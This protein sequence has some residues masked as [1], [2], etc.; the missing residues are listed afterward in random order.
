MANGETDLNTFL[1]RF[2]TCAEALEVEGK[3]KALEI[4]RCLEGSALE[5]VQTLS[6]EQRLNYEAIKKALQHRFRCTEG[7]YRK[8]FKKAKTRA[9]ESQR[10]LVDRIEMYLKN[11]I[12][13]SGFENN[14]EGL[15][16]LLVKD[17]FFG[18]QPQEVRVFLKEAGKQSLDDM[19]NKCQCYR[20]AHDMRENEEHVKINYKDKKNKRDHKKGSETTAKHNQSEQKQTEQKTENTESKT[21]SFV[22][23]KNGEKRKGACWICGASNHKS[24]TCPQRT[25]SSSYNKSGQPELAACLAE[26]TIGAGRIICIPGVGDIPLVAASSDSPI[27]REREILD[28]SKSPVG[29][30]T[31]NGV[32][33]ECLRDTGSTICIVR[34]HLV[35]PEQYTGKQITC[36]LVDRCVKKCPQA[37]IDI[38]TEWYSGKIPVVCSVWRHVSMT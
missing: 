6:S 31:A 19:I 9:G 25:A 29:Y 17:S 36:I 7:Y 15:K 26:Q 37:V 5:L 24:F 4:T 23:K 21:G 38:Q 11:W 22:Q 32:S 16:G 8:W 13:M 28:M 27:N 12:E 3:M 33:V 14:Y 10:S 20:D 1:S 35:R 2:E 30:G 18:A 34:S